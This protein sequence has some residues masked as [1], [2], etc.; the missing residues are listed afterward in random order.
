MVIPQW[1][2]I[3]FSSSRLVK[4]YA[5]DGAEMCSNELQVMPNFW[6]FY[7]SFCEALPRRDPF[8]GWWKLCQT[9]PAKLNY[10]WWFCNKALT[11]FSW[12]SGRVL[13]L[14]AYWLQWLRALKSYCRTVFFNF[15][16]KKS[17]FTQAKAWYATKFSSVQWVNLVFL[18]AKTAETTEK[19]K[20]CS[21]KFKNL[22]FPW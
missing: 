5:K 9:R 8:C 18:A 10:L 16:Y 4:V 20:L 1:C 19:Y 21:M 11:S 7:V 13:G 22:F 17:N 14:S 6:Y 2:F 3:D 12:L 15:W